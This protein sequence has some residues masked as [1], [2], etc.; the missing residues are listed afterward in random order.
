MER[1]T[2]DTLD[3]AE[4][5]DSTDSVS[6]LNSPPFNTCCFPLFVTTIL[7]Y[8][9]ASQLVLFEFYVIKSYIMV[10][11]STI[12]F[13]VAADAGRQNIICVAYLPQHGLS[14]PLIMQFGLKGINVPFILQVRLIPSKKVRH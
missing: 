4:L 13:V 9:C 7:T 10:L 8:S 11:Q 12:S 14:L 1:V 3:S 2:L 6:S 5:F